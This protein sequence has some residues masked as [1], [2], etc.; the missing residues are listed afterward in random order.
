MI[1]PRAWL[2][3]AAAAAAVAVLSGAFIQGYSAGK[4]VTDAAWQARSAAE[5]ARQ[6]AAFNAA[7]DDARAAAEQAE[8]E[9]IDLEQKVRAYEIEVASRG[10]VCR[11]SDAD[12]ERL[13]NIK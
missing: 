7:L 4:S 6:T 12:A 9:M 8:A 1:I 3:A 11:I 13:R 10:D 5:L 2:A